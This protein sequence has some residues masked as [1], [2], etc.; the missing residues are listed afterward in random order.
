VHRGLALLGS[1]RLE[2]VIAA[3]PAAPAAL[4]ARALQA[5]AY[6]RFSQAGPSSR[7]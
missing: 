5:E 3:D 1:A 2:H 4:R 6:A 7:S